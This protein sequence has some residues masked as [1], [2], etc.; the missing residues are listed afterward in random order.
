MASFHLWCA[1]LFEPEP[2]LSYLSSIRYLP[3]LHK[4]NTF[5][6]YTPY[7]LFL[8]QLQ[9]EGKRGF[10]IRF[11]NQY[12]RGVYCQYPIFICFSTNFRPK[13]KRH[14]FGGLPRYFLFFDQLE[15]HRI[16]LIFLYFCKLIK[17]TYNHALYII[18]HDSFIIFCRECFFI[19]IHYCFYLMIFRSN[20]ILFYNF[21]FIGN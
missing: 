3:F 2:A 8:D 9:N 19:F 20:Q 17:I 14:V 15:T 5:T 12:I 18:N 21:I 16:E 6:F 10:S 4:F 7:L 1:A 13:G 11:Q